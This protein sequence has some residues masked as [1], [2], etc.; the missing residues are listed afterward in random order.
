VVGWESLVCLSVAKGSGPVSLLNLVRL[1]IQM[2][3][4][5]GSFE[6]SRTILSNLSYW[7]SI[8]SIRIEAMSHKLVFLAG[9][10]V[11][12]SNRPYVVNPRTQRAKP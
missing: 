7:G 1:K 2:V 10:E 6:L 9:R 4:R 5:P 12:I 3:E 11:D 8:S